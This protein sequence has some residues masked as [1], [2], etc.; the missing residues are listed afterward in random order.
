MKGN[1]TLEL[2]VDSVALN[3]AMSKAVSDAVKSLN[4]EQIVNA[5]VTRRIGK[6]VSK[7][8]QDGTFVRAVAKNVAKEFDANI[9]VPLLDIEE[10]KTMVYANPAKRITP[11]TTPG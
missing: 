2:D 10:L 8:I 3:N 7:S 11:P 1:C 6:S 5:E 9:I 4:I